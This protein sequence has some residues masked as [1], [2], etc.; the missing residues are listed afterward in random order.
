MWPTP[1]GPGS[2]VAAFGPNPLPAFPNG[3]EVSVTI[4]G[5]A[6]DLDLGTY[7]GGCP[8]ALTCGAPPVP[9]SRCYRNNEVS[10]FSYT[11]DPTETITL[12]FSSGAIGPLDVITFYDGFDDTG[13]ILPSGN[14]F[15]G[16]SLNG[17]VI[18]T[19]TNGLY[20]TI[21]SDGSG[22][23][24]DGQVPQV[25][26][27]TSTCSAR[28]IANLLMQR[29]PK[30]RFSPPTASRSMWRSTASVLACPSY[31]R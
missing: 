20:V 15:S 25:Q 29:S 30:I 23:C 13:A 5:G 1:G 17:L 22:S 16:V 31:H 18:T 21:E 4:E 8:I 10:S 2:L 3:T 9:V 6:C 19:T 12:L 7:Y 28:L 24:Q 26:R 11:T 27:S 14:G